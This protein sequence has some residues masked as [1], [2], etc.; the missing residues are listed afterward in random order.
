[1]EKLANQINQLAEQYSNYTAENLSRL[2]KHKSLSTKEKEV[3]LEL[4][5]QM[6]DAGFDEVFI[7]GLGN[8]IGRIGKGEKILAFD[9]I[10]MWLTLVI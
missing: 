2:I 7:D 6:I 3:V 8:V 5:Q 10:S 1:M 4:K 9:A